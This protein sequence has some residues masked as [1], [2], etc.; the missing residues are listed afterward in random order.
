MA[1]PW[2]LVLFPHLRTV[3]PRELAPDSGVDRRDGWVHYPMSV[4]ILFLANSCNQVP[5]LGGSGSP[6]ILDTLGISLGKFTALL[7]S[8]PGW[9]EKGAG[10]N[11]ACDL[12]ST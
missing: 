12:W 6:R 5:V 4:V 2:L 7:F 3:F 9:G 1:D 11:R 10:Q 8:G